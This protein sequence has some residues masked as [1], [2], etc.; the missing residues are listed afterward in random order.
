MVAHVVELRG[1]DPQIAQPIV[2]LVRVDVMHDVLALEREVLRDELPCDAAVVARGLVAGIATCGHV[3]RAR[4]EQAPRLAP[5]R[6]RPLE[7]LTAC[8]ALRRH[9]GALLCDDAESRQAF[10]NSR[11]AD[12]LEPANL[13][14]GQVIDGEVAPNPLASLIHIDTYTPYVNH[15]ARG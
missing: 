7:G 8:R 5:T 14:H 10:T 3:A 2:G 11:A 4:A 12:A 9:L 15:N 6:S 1:K 13:A